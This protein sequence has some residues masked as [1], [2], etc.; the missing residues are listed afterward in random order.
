MAKENILKI[1][2]LVSKWRVIKWQCGPCLSDP[3]VSIRSRMLF[4]DQPMDRLMLRWQ[5]PSTYEHLVTRGREVTLSGPPISPQSPRAQ[6]LLLGRASQ[7]LWLNMTR[8][9]QGSG[10]LV[11]HWGGRLGAGVALLRL[12]WNLPSLSL[13]VAGSGECLQ[14]PFLNPI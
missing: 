9:T 5:W 7:T 11:A 8:R 14:P 10:G 1:I 3:H 13:L 4:S 12:L 2:D 6:P